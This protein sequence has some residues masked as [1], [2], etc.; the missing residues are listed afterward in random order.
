[1]SSPVVILLVVV[2]VLAVVTGGP[3]VT[4]WMLNTLFHLGLPTTWGTWGAAL[5]LNALI[6]GSGGLR[7]RG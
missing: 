4:L 6:G 2:G 3:L 7:Y 1:M 5:A